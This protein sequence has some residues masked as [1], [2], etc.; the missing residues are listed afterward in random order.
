MF[1]KLKPK[2]EW[3]DGTKIVALISPA[4]LNGFNVNWHQL[5]ELLFKRHNDSLV[6]EL[7]PDHDDTLYIRQV[8][9]RELIIILRLIRPPEKKYKPVINGTT[10]NAYRI[11]NLIFI[12]MY[13]GRE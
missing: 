1:R 3:K 4:T 12:Y 13:E 5:E 6:L 8:K 11:R 10:S 7:A 2:R 9:N